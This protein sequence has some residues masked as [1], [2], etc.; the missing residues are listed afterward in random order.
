MTSVLSSTFPS[1]SSSSSTASGP[2][3]ISAPYAP[4]R[5]DDDTAPVPAPVPAPCAAMKR[6]PNKKLRSNPPQPDFQVVQQQV[7]DIV[8]ATRHITTQQLGYYKGKPV[9]DSEPRTKASHE[10]AI[11]HLTNTLPLWITYVETHRDK[12]S[13][14]HLQQLENTLKQVRTRGGAHDAWNVHVLHMSLGTSVHVFMFQM[15]DRVSTVVSSRPLTPPPPPPAP[16]R[17]QPA[18]LPPHM[19]PVSASDDDDTDL[20]LIPP[21]DASQAQAA[22]Q[23]QAQAQA[24]AQQAQPS[25]RRRKQK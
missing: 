19:I 23:A 2:L 10:Y 16:T 18:R 9:T 1:G 11:T 24:E 20:E 25:K 12:I 6:K 7:K 13:R 17:V 22:T 8:A 4:E 3:P 15:S 14:T 5:D 21:L